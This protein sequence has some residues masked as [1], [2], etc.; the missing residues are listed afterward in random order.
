V[1]GAVDDWDLGEGLATRA[2]KADEDVGVCCC[3]VEENCEDMLA[4]LSDC[5]ETGDTVGLSDQT[6]FK[7]SFVFT[8]EKELQS[9]PPKQRSSL[10]SISETS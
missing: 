10:T 1:T 3:D 4:E 5:R 2:G 6:R 7:M 9:S 8:Y